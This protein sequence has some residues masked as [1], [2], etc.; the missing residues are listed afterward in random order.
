VAAPV[1]TSNPTEEP[2]TLAE[3]KAHLRVDFP[4]ADAYIGA[5][6][7]TARVTA[8]E[9]LERTLVHTPWRL[10]LDGFPTAIKLPMPP[11]VT[12][13][14]V[15]YRDED[16]D[17]VELAAQDYVVDTINEPGFVVPAP[18]ARWPA[19][20]PGINGVRVN[21]TAGYGATGSSVPAP[22]RHWML[23]A[24]G[25]MYHLRNRSSEKAAVPQ[26]FADSLLDPYRI[27][28]T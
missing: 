14:S 4:D 12:V 11:I 26:H 22:I 5:L 28:S 2:V 13:E 15:Q 8:E 18:G 6:I 24:I 9:R 25:D 10:T 1:R 7:T 17:W 3:A 21:Y 27:W 20:G 23:L 19:V 16:G